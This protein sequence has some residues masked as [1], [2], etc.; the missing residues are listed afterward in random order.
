MQNV[1]KSSV[2]Q[3]ELAGTVFGGCIFCSLFTKLDVCL[4]L[5]GCCRHWTFKLI[6]LKK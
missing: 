4:H 6:D 3:C 1:S 2:F 5:F